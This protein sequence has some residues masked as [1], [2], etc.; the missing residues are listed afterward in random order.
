MNVDALA[1]LLIGSLRRIG[2][3][4]GPKSLF[5]LS[6]RWLLKRLGVDFVSGPT[7]LKTAVIGDS[8]QIKWKPPKRPDPAWERY[9]VDWERVPMSER[10]KMEVDEATTTARL[11]KL[12]PGGLYHICV[13]MGDGLLTI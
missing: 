10:M 7:D 13:S 1:S 4:Y 9:I 3:V 5:A 2:H 6:L 11:E 12:F 8:I